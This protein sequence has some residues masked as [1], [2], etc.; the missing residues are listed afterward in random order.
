[1]AAEEAVEAITV[2]GS[3]ADTLEYLGKEGYNVLNLADWTAEKNISWLNDAINR[4]DK[5][6]L[7]TD[8]IQHQALM[9]SLD[10]ASAFLD[11]EM[12]YLYESGFIN[13]GKYMVR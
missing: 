8:P 5:I 13:K 11:L 4:G 1:M 9:Q 3:R 7:A 12:P 10:K 6:M 2:I